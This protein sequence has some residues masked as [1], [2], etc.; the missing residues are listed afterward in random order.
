MISKAVEDF[1]IDLS[2][3]YMIGDRYK[4]VL[5]AHKVGLK[6]IMVLTGYGKGEYT[7]QRDTWEQKPDFLCENLLLAAQYICE[8]NQRTE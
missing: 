5:F 4:D 1:D 8:H 2:R 6:S 3:S 7:Y